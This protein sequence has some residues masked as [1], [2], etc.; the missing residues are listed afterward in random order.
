MS[1]LKENLQKHRVRF[2][3]IDN[4]K[5]LSLRKIRLNALENDMQVCYDI[6]QI[7]HLRIAAFRAS[8]PDIYDLYTT[9]KNTRWES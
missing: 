5:D 1:D 9:V 2:D 3:E 6:P 7:G 4:C 8:F